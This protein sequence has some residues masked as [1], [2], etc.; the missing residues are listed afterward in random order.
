[1]QQLTI[2]IPETLAQRLDWLAAA[3]EKSVQQIALERLA[4]LLEAAPAQPSG[5][6][7]TIRQAR[8]ESP[9]LRGEDVDEFE[10][11]MAA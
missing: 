8:R 3:Q 4:L 1:M 7:A 9:H 5:P 11:A 6:P 2:E 10:R